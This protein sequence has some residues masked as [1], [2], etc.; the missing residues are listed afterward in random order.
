MKYI[1]V[2]LIA[3]TIMM[4]IGA[5]LN[6]HDLATKPC[7]FFANYTTAEIPLRCLTTPTK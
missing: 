1:T 3:I 2:T 4:V 6:S 7:S 5:I